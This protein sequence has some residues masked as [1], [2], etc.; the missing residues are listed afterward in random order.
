MAMP[1]PLGHLCRGMKADCIEAQQQILS[2]RT[3]TLQMEELLRRVDDA[4]FRA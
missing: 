1:D 2:N 4:V 3:K